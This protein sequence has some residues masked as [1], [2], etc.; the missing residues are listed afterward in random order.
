V[1][2]GGSPGG[3][4]TFQVPPYRISNASVVAVVRNG[5]MATVFARGRVNNGP[6]TT[7]RI[8]LFDNGNS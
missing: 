4:F 3:T 7:F 8:D 5:N 6:V 1:S 2:N